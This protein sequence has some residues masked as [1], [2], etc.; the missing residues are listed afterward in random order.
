[1]E[2]VQP[3]S[4]CNDECRT[5]VDASPVIFFRVSV[6]ESYVCGWIDREW[7][8]KTHIMWR[9]ISFKEL[10][11]WWLG[12]IRTYLLLFVLICC[13]GNVSVFAMVARK[14]IFSPLYLGFFLLL[15]SPACTFFQNHPN[16]IYFFEALILPT[17]IFQNQ[18]WNSLVN[19]NYEAYLLVERLRFE[20]TNLLEFF[21]AW[22]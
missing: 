8:V 14:Y 11:N 19:S 21:F 12:V 22:G 2:V 13:C 3:R 18:V 16:R 15:F 9:Q 1:M 6:C 4:T 20:P 10:Y 17:Q 7:D 5:Y